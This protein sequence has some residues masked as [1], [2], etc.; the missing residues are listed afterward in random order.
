MQAPRALFA[1][2]PELLDRQVSAVL[3]SS[4]TIRTTT[5]QTRGGPEMT[6]S[7]SNLLLRAAAV[8]ALLA[9][10]APAAAQY[11]YA[12]VHESS[13]RLRLGQFQPEGDSDYWNDKFNDF[14]GDIGQFDDIV[15]GGDFIL[16]LG[17]RTG[18]IFSGD[19]Y[20]GEDSQAYI[21][22]VDAFGSPIVHT[23]R[24]AIASATAGLVVNLTPPD[25]PV[26]PYLGVGGGIYSWEIEESGDFIDFG[27]E[28]LE[29][30]SD[31]FRDSNTTLGFFGLAGVDVPI[32]PHWSMF[33]E[34]R[35]QE[36][37]EDL[38]DDFEGLGDLDLSGLQI[39]GG[40]GWNF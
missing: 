37:E 40:F 22:F 5:I 38:N 25:A 27:V 3:D 36:V 28:P 12:G 17:P 19:L 11:H 7:T 13:F 16:S 26:V 9:V 23:T 20:E 15:I 6:A 35:W 33:A 1:L 14:T 32:G 34:G 18:L 30:F 21:D 10:A 24:L 29:I 39:F 8:A 31:T 4:D 2:A